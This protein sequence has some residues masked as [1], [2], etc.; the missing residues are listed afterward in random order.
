MFE[1]TALTGTAGG[2]IGGMIAGLVK[3]GMNSWDS[4]TG[5]STAF[6]FVRSISVIWS[7]GILSY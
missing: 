3:L 5:L 4:L 2:G 7:Y 6:E 1:A